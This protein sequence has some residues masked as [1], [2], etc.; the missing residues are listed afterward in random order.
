VKLLVTGSDGF[1]GEHATKYAARRGYEVVG[2]DLKQGSSILSS[3]DVL[4]AVAGCTHILH[5]AAYTGTQTF[6][7]NLHRNYQ[8]N[9]CGFLNMLDAARES[10]VS[11][12]VYASSSAVYCGNSFCEDDV[13][14]GLQSHYAKSKLMDE[15]VAASYQ[16]PTIGLRY[17]N[18]YGP[19]EEKKG[20]CCSPIQHFLNSRHA[21]VPITIYGDGTQAKDFIHVSDVVAITFQLMESDAEGIYN[22][23]TG[24]ATSFNRLAELV[25]GPVRYTP[26]PYS[27]YQHYSKANTRKLCAALGDYRFLPV[28]SGIAGLVAGVLA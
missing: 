7:H 19:G 9:V 4:H 24:V 8:T 16:I 12:F 5:L 28:E 25:G 6:Q 23:G 21:G 26:N 2:F 15:M 22:V 20:D 27:V 18:V 1:I 14:S 13:I 10:H 3:T 17:F 11:K